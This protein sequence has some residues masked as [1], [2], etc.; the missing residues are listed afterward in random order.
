MPVEQGPGESDEPASAPV[1]H[2]TLPCRA[3]ARE[4]DD[5]LINATEYHY[6]AQG[7]L[8][9]EYYQQAAVDDAPRLL[10]SYEY[11]SVGNQVVIT[12][13]GTDEYVLSMTTQT[14]DNKGNRLTRAV[15]HGVDGEVESLISYTYDDAGRLL[16]EEATGWGRDANW[17][18]FYTYDEQ[19]RLLTEL[20]VSD[21]DPEFLHSYAYGE[22]GASSEIA[23]DVS[24]DGTID[25][26]AKSLYDESG[27]VLEYTLDEGMDGILEVHWVSTW[28]EA[29]NELTRE[30]RYTNGNPDYSHTFSYDPEGREVAVLTD[31][32]RDGTI[33]YI[34]RTYYE[35]EFSDAPG[36]VDSSSATGPDRGEVR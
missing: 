6:N 14:F 23:E 17:G 31:V 15:D 5:T 24:A 18:N 26:L 10:Y 1:S 16:S 13:Y 2:S 35:C 3:E 34:S 8:A 11:D 4:G 20:R 33:D 29:G 12:E 36:P 27:H 21:G 19:G 28:N 7:Q 30:E 25:A 32:E 22:D 9:F